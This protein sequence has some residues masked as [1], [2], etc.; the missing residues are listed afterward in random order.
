MWDCTPLLAVAVGA[1]SPAA[2][3][4]GAQADCIHRGPRGGGSGR[5]ACL[6][7]SRDSSTAKI[8]GQVCGHNESDFCFKSNRL[9]TASHWGPLGPEHCLPP[10][11]SELPS[12][13]SSCHSAS[14]IRPYIVAGTRADNAFEG[15][16]AATA[17]ILLG[18]QLLP[19]L[20]VVRA[21]DQGGGFPSWARLQPGG[22]VSV[23][24]LLTGSGWA[25]GLLLNKD[26]EA[27]HGPCGPGLT[28][29]NSPRFLHVT[30]PNG[31]APL[32]LPKPQS[33]SPQTT[34]S[35]QLLALCPSMWIVPCVGT[36]HPALP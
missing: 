22:P 11:S 28:G 3:G 34:G 35:P 14:Q 31:S 9:H 17:E 19:R 21:S 18:V 5:A 24:W 29:R 26:T 16:C 23:G 20:W 8:R 36:G 10:P 25:V 2:Q 1:Q 13:L 33:Q 30:F 7:I 4:A 6:L 15:P 32:F 12:P 27:A